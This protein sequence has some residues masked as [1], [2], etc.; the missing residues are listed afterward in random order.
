MR[1]LK[2]VK[3]NCLAEGETTGH[4]HRVQVAVMEREDGVRL[5]DGETVVTHEEHKEIKL[6]NKQWASDKVKEFD[7]V[8]EMERKVI[9]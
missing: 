2:K 1:K 8:S 7:Y 6:P 5:F 3:G 9:D 4:A